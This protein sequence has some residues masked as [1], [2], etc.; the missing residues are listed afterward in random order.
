MTILSA[1]RLANTAGSRAALYYAALKQMC[2]KLNIIEGKHLTKEESIALSQPSKVDINAAIQWVEGAGATATMV[3]QRV[4]DVY[5]TKEAA[6][7][8]LASKERCVC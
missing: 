6:A 4:V 3:G 1:F 2:C 7:I 8:L 5:G